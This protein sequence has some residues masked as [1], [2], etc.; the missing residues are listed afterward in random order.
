MAGVDASVEATLRVI[1]NY[2]RMTPALATAGQ[3]LEAELEAVARAGFEVVIDLALLDAEY[4]LADEPGLVRSL[5]MTFEH[6]PVIWER[7]TPDDLHRFFA[8]MR[9]HQGRRIFLHCAANMRASVFLALYR[10]L[11][12]G[13]DEGAAFAAVHDIWQ[14]DAT[15]QAFIRQALAAGGRPRMR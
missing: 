15:W 3:P 14:P 6:V 11:E 8:L 1:Y 7:P 4:S 12:L 5:G 10:I 9:R 2:R 13:W